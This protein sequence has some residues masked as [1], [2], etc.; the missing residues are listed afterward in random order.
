MD[1]EHGATEA[2]AFVRQVDFP[3]SNIAFDG[4]FDR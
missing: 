4:Q 1:R 3:P 2:A